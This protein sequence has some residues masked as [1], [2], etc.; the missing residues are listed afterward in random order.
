MYHEDT[1]ILFPMRVAPLLRDLRGDEWRA[2]V[3]QA[4]ATPEGSLERL[5]FCLLLIRMS[6]CLTCH[7]HSYRA[8]RGCTTC[9]TQTVRRF[10]GLD[11]ELKQEFE[12]ALGEVQSYLD[13]QRAPSEPYLTK[14]DG[15]PS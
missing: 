8:L 3:D 9:A 15:L 5:A 10:R 7:P 1:E 6:N 14:K 11:Q 13:P 12:R 4:C 2:L